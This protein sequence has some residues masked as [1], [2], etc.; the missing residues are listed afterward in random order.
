MNKINNDLVVLLCNSK[1][2]F[3]KESIDLLS[4]CL[5]GGKYKNVDHIVSDIDS[6]IIQLKS[7]IEYIERKRDGI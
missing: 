7:L 2:S 1:Y 3:N 4:Q 6:L 5:G